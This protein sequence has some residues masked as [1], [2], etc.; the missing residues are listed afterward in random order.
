MTDLLVE[1][2]DRD[3]IVRRPATGH[4]IRYRRVLDA[5][6]LEAEN[7]QRFS[8]KRG[9]PPMPKQRHSVGFDVENGFSG[10]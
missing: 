9:K 6:M 10:R 4:S 7:K 3:I 8:H 2:Q 5:P 1:V